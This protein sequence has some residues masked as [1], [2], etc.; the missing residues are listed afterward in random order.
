MVE[1]I[2]APDGALEK[3]E[4]RE[5]VFDSASVIDIDALEL[6]VQSRREQLISSEEPLHIDVSNL[7]ISRSNVTKKRNNA[8]K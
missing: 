4:I 5:F 6:F 7:L 1:D 8:I 2:D 3:E